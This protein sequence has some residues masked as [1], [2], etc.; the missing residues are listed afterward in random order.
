MIWLS[1]SGA[2]L[3]IAILVWRLSNNLQQNRAGKI[4]DHSHETVIRVFSL[5]PS[6]VLL[7]IPLGYFGFLV[8]TFMLAF[9]WVTFFDGMFGVKRDRG[10]WDLGTEDGKYDANTDNFFQNLKLWEHQA[11]KI[12]GCA[13][14]LLIYIIWYYLKNIRS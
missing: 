10:F 9:W 5:L 4:I 8:V 6:F 1:I 12:G 3:F 13:L 11:I 2:V 14:T 7:S